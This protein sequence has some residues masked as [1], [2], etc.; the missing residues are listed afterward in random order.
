MG[1]SLSAVG[2]L[3]E[4]QQLW[5]VLRS[6]VAAQ[7]Q[8][9][10]GLGHKRC[11]PQGLQRCGLAACVWALERQYTGSREL[12]RLS[13]DH[14]TATSCPHVSSAAKLWILP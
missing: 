4:P 6:S 11:Q 10:T 7:R 8:E 5:L 1:C 9:Q 2:H 14:H 12:V 3:V 13:S